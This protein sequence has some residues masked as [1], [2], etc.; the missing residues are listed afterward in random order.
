MDLKQNDGVKQ[1]I[2]VYLRGYIHGTETGESYEEYLLLSELPQ[3]KESLLSNFNLLG[4]LRSQ[5]TV[6]SVWISKTLPLR[7][8]TERLVQLL[9]LTTGSWVS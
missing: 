9:G 5:D 2:P 6:Y 8:P 3:V 4:V 7:L 1:Y